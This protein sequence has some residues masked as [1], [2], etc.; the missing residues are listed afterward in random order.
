MVLFFEEE[1]MRVTC[2]YRPEAVRPNC[3]KDQLWNLCERDLQNSDEMVLGVDNFNG[4]VGRRSD[5]FESVGG[6]YGLVKEM[7]REE[8]C[9]SFAMK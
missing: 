1:V 9:L 4:D 3:E 5:G 2:A 6:G 7:L 8:D